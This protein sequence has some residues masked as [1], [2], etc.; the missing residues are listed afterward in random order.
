MNKQ[1]PMISKNLEA[2]REAAGK[3]RDVICYYDR[4]RSELHIGLKG[5]ND[6]IT[7]ADGEAEKVIIETIRNHFPDD[8]ILAEESAETIRLDDRR[9]WIIDPLDGTT[10][11][12]HGVP[13]YCVSIALWEN[14][15]PKSALVLEVNSGECFTAEA[16]MGAHCN[17]KPLS[18]SSVSKPAHALLAT[19]FPYRDLG[20]ID[21][22]LR[23]FKAFMHETQGV[24]RPG[25]AAWD[26]CLV[27]A[28]R[29]D[30]FYEY[31]LSPW[32]VA[33]GSLLIREAGGVVTDWNEGD[34]WLFGRR[35]VAGNPDIWNYLIRRIGDVIPEK[36][37]QTK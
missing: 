33:A 12:A 1:Q 36:H 34:D 17:D 15:Q 14:Q 30:G 3:A 21:D 4:N 26:L 24:R 6:L 25:S 10:N 2:A 22:Y 13:L 19:G 31:G 35:I 18:V 5:K 32:D 16:G 28:G 11:F 7:E 23:L 37:R 20:L 29:C 27:A 9:T 8:A